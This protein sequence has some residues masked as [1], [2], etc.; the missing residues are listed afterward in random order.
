MTAVCLR[1]WEMSVQE[2]LKT[3]VDTEQDEERKKQKTVVTNPQGNT[4]TS[5]LHCAQ[6]GTLIWP[7]WLHT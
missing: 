7:S 4:N 3:N 6:V 5:R 2:V 1:L